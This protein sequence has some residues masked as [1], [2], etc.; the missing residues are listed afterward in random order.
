[1]DP[2][3]IVSGKIF[4][5]STTFKHDFS[6]IHLQRTF[7]P[8]SF[9]DLVVSQ[10]LKPGDKRIW[11]SMKIFIELRGETSLI[12]PFREGSKDWQWDVPT[13]GFKPGTREH[14]FLHVTAGDSSSISYLL[15]MVIG[16]DGYE[17]R[18]E[19]H[20]DSIQVTSSLNDSKLVVAESC[21]VTL[22][23]FPLFLKLIKP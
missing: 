15:P 8:S 14:A 1:M 11:T 5:G 10:R 6:R 12:L 20:L 2:G 22:N 18:L 13:I 21:R 4:F 19:V 9:S 3:R 16:P 7:F 17:S 23:H